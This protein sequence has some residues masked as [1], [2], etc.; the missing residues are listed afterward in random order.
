MR[1]LLILISVAAGA[2]SIV[3]VGSFLVLARLGYFTPTPAESHNL[4]ED[5]SQSSSRFAAKTWTISDFNVPS[6]PLL[7]GDRPLVVELAFLHS[8]L[9]VREIQSNSLS[10][11]SRAV[12]IRVGDL[13]RGT[14]NES[15]QHDLRL[16]PFN[17]EYAWQALILGTGA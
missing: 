14:A 2:A 1:D 10:A 5:L 17:G 9:R 16:A 11:V 15:E 8:D 12:R 7:E 3:G 4:L 6:G 13:R